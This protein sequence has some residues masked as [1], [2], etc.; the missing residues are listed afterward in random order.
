LPPTMISSQTAPASPSFTHTL[1]MAGSALPPSPS[2]P[3]DTTTSTAHTIPLPSFMTSTASM[4]L[5]T[6][7][8]KEQPR[9]WWHRMPSF[10]SSTIRPPPPRAAP[11]SLTAVSPKA[12][13]RGSGA[14]PSPLSTPFALPS[15]PFKTPDTSR[16]PSP[17]I[18]SSYHPRKGRAT[19]LAALHA[20]LPPNPSDTLLRDPAIATLCNAPMA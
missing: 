20:A 18:S 10:A 9:Q 3:P 16:L 5:A 2:G 8:L 14:S 4:P 1:R 15:L 13:L 6:H 11:A 12:P 17:L 7:T 19:S